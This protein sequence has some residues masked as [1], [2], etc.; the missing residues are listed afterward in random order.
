M[1]LLLLALLA[2]PTWA[3]LWDRDTLAT[4]AA[5][6][7]EVPRVVTGRFARNPPLYYEMRLKRVSTALAKTPEKLELYDDAAVACDRLGRVDEAI[8][9]MA[10]KL[11]HIKDDEHRY[12]YLAN[13]GTFHAH[14][15]IKGGGKHDARQDLERARDLIREAIELSPKAHFGREK[16]QLLLIEGLRIAE[17]QPGT[18]ARLLSF[19]RAREDELHKEAPKAVE[20]L[21]GLITLGAAWRSVDVHMALADALALTRAA[22]LMLIAQLRAKELATAGGRS[23]VKGAPT[24]ELLL[25]GLQR[26]S[27]IESSRDKADIKDWFVEAR[28]EAD[29]WHERRTSFMVARLKSGQHPDTHPDFW[30]S[31][32]DGSP[33]PTRTVWT[34]A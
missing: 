4:E 34:A 15:W 12:R 33:P 32:D 16:Y 21:L 1:R 6:L 23:L 17:A 20:G 3:C 10:K 29:A 31:W 9:W 5:G 7:P 13:L 11:L 18:E 2:S 25:R 30:Q 22:S 27:T 14:R 26:H 19:V 8:A 28:A 24:G